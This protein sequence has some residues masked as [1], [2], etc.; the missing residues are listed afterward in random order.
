MIGEHRVRRELGRYGTVV[1]I[2]SNVFEHLTAFKGCGNPAGDY[3]FIGLEEGFS[4]DA[5]D[6]VAY[7]TVLSQEIDIRATWNAIEDVHHTR[8]SLGIPMRKRGDNVWYAI[9]RMV[10]KL[11]HVDGWNKVEQSR[12]YKEERLGR[13]DGDTFLADLYP[14]PSESLGIWPYPSLY[15]SRKKYEETIFPRRKKLIQDLWL[16]HTPRYVF[17]YGKLDDEWMRFKQLFPANYEPRTF[18]KHDIQLAVVGG[19]VIVLT[20][21]LTWLNVDP[22]GE[23]VDAVLEYEARK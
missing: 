6:G 22:L 18:D 11:N 9:S 17:C 20:H 4:F 21:H 19:S 23:I 15:P 5:K 14:L 16:D 12:P 10:L 13:L 3:W 2:T 1:S 7:E 8:A